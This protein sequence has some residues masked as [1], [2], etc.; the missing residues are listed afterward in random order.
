MSVFLGSSYGTKKT[1]RSS[2][3]AFKTIFALLNISSPSRRKVYPRAQ[4]DIFMALATMASH[5]AATICRVA[6]C[7]AEDSWLLSRN[8]GA[9]IVTA[10]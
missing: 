5:K 9:V 1:C 6:K 7:A 8:T 10:L 2:K 4:I 3:N